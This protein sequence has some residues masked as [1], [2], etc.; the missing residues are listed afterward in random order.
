MIL[1]YFII[2]PAVRS[3]VAFENKKLNIR[4]RI[5]KYFFPFTNPRR[6]VCN[7]EI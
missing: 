6:G 5:N 2:V 1:L 7:R 4:A 3:C